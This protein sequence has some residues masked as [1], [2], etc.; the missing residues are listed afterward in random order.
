[1][2]KKIFITVIVILSLGACTKQAETSMAAGREFT[3]DKLFTAEG[4]T[5]YR[6][7]D[8]GRSRYFSKCQNNST[9][10]WSES[11][12]KNCEVDNEVTTSYAK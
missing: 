9:T 1:M 11:C 2:F 12:G 8:A 5:V 3:V 10:S 7:Q 6:F 4:C